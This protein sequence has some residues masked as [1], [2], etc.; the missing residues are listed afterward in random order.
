MKLQA[1]LKA[2]LPLTALSGAALLLLPA[3]HS[4][5][6][7]TLGGNLGFTQR[8]VRVFNNFEDFHANNNTNA[9]PN[10]PGYTGCYLALWKGTADWASE[11]RG[12]TGEGDSTQ[13][14]GLGSGGANFDAFWAGAADGVGSSNSNTM[15]AVSGCESGLVA[16]CETPISDG[17]RIRYCEE[18]QWDDGPGP[19]LNNRMDL[20]GVCSHEY[21]HALGLGHSDD[22]SATMYPSINFNGV[23]ERSIEADDVA[24]VQF[25]YGVRD[26]N[27][28]KITNISVTGLTMTITGSGFSSADNQV[29]FTPASTTSAGGT[30]KI[31]LSNVSSD[32][33]T[34]S[35]TIPSNAGPGDVMVK[36]SGNS[37]GDISNAW[38]TTIIPGGGCEAPAN[39]CTSTP[40]SGSPFGAVMGFQGTASYSSND[41]V[42]QCYGAV[43]NQFGI[44]YYGPAQTSA[45]FGN[46]Q[47][48]VGAGFQGTFRLPI[49][50]TNAFGDV[51]YALDY[52]QAP[53]NAGNGIIVD[54]MEYNFQFWFRD[55]GVGAN[56]NLSDGLNVIF[57]P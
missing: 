13:A 1:L 41:L 44:F 19:P 55:P 12:G 25:V 2:L 54:G 10:F 6:Y 11:L 34:L 22:G 36:N 32:G 42:L 52:G 43:P 31:T 15:S 50:Q 33:S 5:A 24:G 56:F 47:R 57:C 39:Y 53:M 18:W 46:G 37:N 3:Q 30:P 9:E 51:S 14:G 38:P 23:I 35:F 4:R 49:L 26:A 16:Y 8:D 28:P 7:S 40:N 48:C 27:K 21:G 20:Q 29:W 45:P 17:W